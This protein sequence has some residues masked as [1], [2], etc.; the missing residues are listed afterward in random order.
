[1]HPLLIALMS[2]VGF[3]VAYHTYG[4][5]LGSKIFKLS[6]S[7]VCPSRR[8]ADGA[9]YVPTAKFV[10]FGHHF[11]SIAGTGPIVG[12]AIAIMWG[13]LPAL[14]WVLLGSVFIGAVHDFGALVVSLRNNGQTVGD[15]AGRV[16]NRRVRLLFLLILFMALTIV[17]A[18]FG[19][20]IASV[21]KQFPTAIVPCVIQ[22]PIAVGIGWWLHRRGAS[23]LVPSLV[24]LALMY[25]TVIY[26][27][28]GLLHTINT[29][30][31]GWSA[32]TWVVLLL[33]Y[34]YVASVL[35]VWALLQPRDYINSLQ[36]ISVLALLVIGL[37]VASFAGGA[38]LSDGTR[39][40]LSLAAP[41]INLNPTGAPLMFP[42]L[43]IT[44]ACGAISGFHCLVSSGTSSKQLQ[45]EPDARFVGYGGMLMEGFLAVLVILACA[46]GLGLGVT[47]ADGSVLLGGE[48]WGTRYSVWSAQLGPLVS[49]FVDGSANFLKTLGIPAEVAVAL[50]GVFVA[51]FA[52]TT[53]DSA[54]RLQRYVVQELAATFAPRR[55][56]GPDP[57]A[58]LRGRHGAT[59]FAV[60]VAALVAA[61]P[62]PG[63]S[64][65]LAN[66]G[67]GGLL[68]W[69]LFGATNQLLGGLS[70][71]V[72]T[73]HLWR[74]GITMAFLVP[75]MIFM[76]I[77][78]P[79]AML[80]QVFVGGADHPSWWSQ[81]NWLLVSVA[82]ITL[83]LEAW[84]IVEAVKLFPRVKGVIE[85]AAAEPERVPARAG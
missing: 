43:F 69:P 68:L 81:G 11:A 54:C 16:L 13:W 48:A 76:L 37:V 14:L 26:G 70:F 60:A 75:P 21:F 62:P 46:A 24:A 41:M 18:I 66:A 12:P 28:V 84:M 36:L 1:M 63:K 6:A 42:F 51:S 57:L 9:D 38:P 80:W 52:G 33:G 35:P 73:F 83:A 10:V 2:G 85:V 5:W 3:V 4:R 45:S 19:L 25:V 23:L 31:A 72:I 56:G 20:V 53:L 22:V 49:A 67:Q 7:A 39:P 82:L 29:M 71:L 59:V 77:M 79:W 64:W 47:Q 34:S 58:W 61:A 78:P 17:L 74:R 30:M 27:D 44:V 65:A 50:M 40:S 8:M 55:T 32:W 15:I